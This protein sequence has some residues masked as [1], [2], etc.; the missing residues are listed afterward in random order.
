M[1]SLVRGVSGFSLSVARLV[2]QAKGSDRKGATPVLW[3][4]QLGPL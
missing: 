1:F 4:C 3:R 2:A